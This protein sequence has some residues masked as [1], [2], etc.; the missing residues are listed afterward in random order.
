SSRRRHTRWPRDWSS[1]VCSSDLFVLRSLHVVPANMLNGASEEPPG[2]ARGIK[3]HIVE[4]WINLVD[5]ELGDGARRVVLAGVP[6]A[7]EEIGRAS[8]RESVYGGEVGGAV[9]S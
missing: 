7:L 2:A 5:N 3:N 1:D 8:C 9:R 4:L 6:C